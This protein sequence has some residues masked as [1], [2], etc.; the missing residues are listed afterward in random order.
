MT[1]PVPAI[2]I[3]V[4]ALLLAAPAAAA[5]AVKSPTFAK[6]VAPIFQAK[7]EACHR[8][9]SMAPMSLVTY[10]D[11]RPWAK[12]IKARVTARQM[13]PWHID[14]NVGIQEFKNDR[15]LSDQEID[16]IARWVDGGAP[17]G[18]PKDMPAGDPVARRLGL[19]LRQAVRRA[20]RSHRQVAVVHHA[21]PRPGRVGQALD[22]VGR[23]GAAV[24]ARD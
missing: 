15:S 18:D 2:R 23:H 3:S 4:C 20:A 13:P 14:K 1:G 6:D 11:V 17:M 10:Q 24:G 21:G 5:D 9:D 7:C 19:E 12:S 22:A 16:T 8:T